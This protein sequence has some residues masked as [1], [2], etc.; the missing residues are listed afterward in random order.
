MH[1]IADDYSCLA[2]ALFGN[3][4]MKVSGSAWAVSSAGPGVAAGLSSCGVL[5]RQTSY[6]DAWESH[7]RCMAIPEAT[8][9]FTER[10]EPYWVIE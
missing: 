10:V 6:V 1:G 5:A 4:S 9:T 8:P 2:P 7:H 3:G